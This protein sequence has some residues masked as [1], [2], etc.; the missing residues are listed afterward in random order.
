MSIAK[1]MIAEANRTAAASDLQ[2]NYNLF[3][4]EMKGISKIKKCN[5]DVDIKILES[6]A[7]LKHLIRNLNT[8]VMFGNKI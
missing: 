4:E 8:N 1:E 6:L 3:N 7:E 2:I 5:E